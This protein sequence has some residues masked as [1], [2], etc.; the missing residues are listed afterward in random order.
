MAMGP[1]EQEITNQLQ[2]AV[3]DSTGAAQ[4]AVGDPH[5]WRTMPQ[6]GRDELVLLSLTSLSD[7]IRRLAREIDETRATIADN[8]GH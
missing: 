3:A 5:W 1:L 6:D 2:S 8:R 4:Y 7:A